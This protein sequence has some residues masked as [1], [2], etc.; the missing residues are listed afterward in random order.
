MH[1]KN[2]KMIGYDFQLLENELNLDGYFL[3]DTDNK[4]RE[5]KVYVDL[6]IPINKTIYLDRSSRSFLYDVENIQNIYDQ[7]MA[8]HYF[9]MTINGLD[10]L[11]CEDYKFNSDKDSESF[12]LKIDKSGV[13]VEVHGDNNEK[14]E[15][16][17]DENGVLIQSSKDT[18]D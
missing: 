13:R 5:Q 15:V 16:K 12:N 17:I 9:Q 4:Y 3:A 1:G 14:A 7:D 2:A 18:V 6:Y 11:D 10:C 8:E